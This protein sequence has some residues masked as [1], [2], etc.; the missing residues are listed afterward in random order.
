MYHG[1]P[2]PNICHVMLY[3]SPCL[4][5]FQVSVRLAKAAGA[6]GTCLALL[7]LVARLEGLAVLQGKVGQPFL[8]WL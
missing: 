2:W 7:C 1:V 6:G 8:G 4:K 5:M 3:P